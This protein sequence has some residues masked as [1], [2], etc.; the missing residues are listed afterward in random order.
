MGSAFLAMGLLASSVTE[1]Q[2]VAAF[3]TFGVLLLFWVIGWS[4]DYAGGVAGKI[5]SHLSIVEHYESFARGVLDTRDVLY[6]VNFTLL[7]LF[8]TLRSLESRRWNG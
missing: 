8:L 5:L 3:L 1:N 7:A 6:Y 4:A 2:I